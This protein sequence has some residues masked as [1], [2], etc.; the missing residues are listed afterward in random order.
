MRD[1]EL[2]REYCRKKNRLFIWNSAV[3]LGFILVMGFSF[4]IPLR[5]FAVDIGMTE[6]SVIVISIY[7]LLFYCAYFLVMLGLR[8]YEGVV[9]EREFNGGNQSFREWFLPVLKREGLTFLVL[10]PVV[11]TA[12]FCWKPVRQDGG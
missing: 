6:N 1:D 12:I 10:L 4:S 11:Q 3:T 7:F 2:A 8:Y 9:L 5:K